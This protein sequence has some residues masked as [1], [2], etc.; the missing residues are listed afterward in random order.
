MNPVTKTLFIVLGSI[1]GIFLVPVILIVFHDYIYAFIAI[2]SIVACFWLFGYYT[3]QEFYPEIQK[4][5]LEEEQIFHQFHGDKD[6][7]RYYKGFRKHF[8]GELDLEQLEKWFERHP[9]KD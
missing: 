6:K 1:F 9:H 8:D 3:Y 2:T 5:Y 7:I 4:R